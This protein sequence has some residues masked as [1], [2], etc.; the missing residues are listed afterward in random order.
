MVLRPPSPIDV[1]HQA[2]HGLAR[3]AGIQQQPF[4]LCCDLQG[5]L[6][7][8]GDNPVSLTDKL[9]IT[10]QIFC[11]HLDIKVENP[12]MSFG[13]F[14]MLF[15]RLLVVAL[16]WADPHNSPRQAQ[17]TRRQDKPSMRV[18]T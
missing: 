4:G 13:Q 18:G 16:A 5:L 2:C 3:I 7:T 6:G 17:G 14:H 12:G 1:G 11:C 15:R 8:F 9:C 10:L